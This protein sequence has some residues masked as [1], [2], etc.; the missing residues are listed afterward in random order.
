MQ[1]HQT[2]QNPS[3]AYSDE[4]LGT[5]KT[6]FVLCVVVGCIGILWP[7]LFYPMFFG[8]SSPPLPQ[9]RG[10]VKKLGKCCDVVLDKDKFFNSTLAASSITFGP[11]LFRRHDKMYQDE[12][13]M[14]FQE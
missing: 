11:D 2:R 10:S 4:G 8:N 9:N 5:K 14:T 6:I 1:K 7:K 13:S 12:I 3:P